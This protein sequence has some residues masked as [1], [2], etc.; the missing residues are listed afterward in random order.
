MSEPL[1]DLKRAR[2]LISNDD[3]IRADG[4]AVLERLMAEIAG[5][6]WVVAPET[7]QSAASHSLTMRRPLFVRA[8]EGQRRF[9]VDGT[10]TDCVLLAVHQVMRGHPPD[11]VLS[12][13][14]QGA[15]LGEDAFYSG[16]VA[17]AREGALLGIPSLALSQMYDHAKPVPWQVAA[18]WT[19]RVL[20]HLVSR[21]WPRGVLINVNFPDRP[22]GDVAGIAITRQGRRKIGGAMV[23]GVDP[24]G[25][26]YFWI[27][28]D[29]E[30]DPNVAGTDI[31][32]VRRG[33]VAVTPLSLDSTHEATLTLL[34]EALP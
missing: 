15:N 7:E 6:V 22:A 32:A 30:E 11:L 31:E 10:P 8:A 5:E 23:R 33:C 21:R 20:A 14:N 1:L 13:V 17:A 26:P 28:G 12:G 3:G 29:R 24:R 2:V 4:L 27:G 19:P 25:E 9:T 18:A 34:Q 16:T